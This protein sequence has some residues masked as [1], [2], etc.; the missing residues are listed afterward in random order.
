[1]PSK[2]MGDKAIRDMLNLTVSG[3]PIFRLNNAILGCFTCYE[4]LRQILDSLL[5]H[6]INFQSVMTGC[7]DLRN[8]QGRDRC[9]DHYALK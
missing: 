9:D 3:W 1:M 8:I 4:G 5:L 2:L 6:A 7:A